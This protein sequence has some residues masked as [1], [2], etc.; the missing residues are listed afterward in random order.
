M[1][2][3]LLFNTQQLR[4]YCVSQTAH[5]QA[6][7]ICHIRGVGTQWR[8]SAVPALIGHFLGSVEGPINLQGLEPVCAWSTASHLWAI[9]HWKTR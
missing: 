3:I 9:G 7:T 5:M 8:I 1:V 2:I 4:A 6:H